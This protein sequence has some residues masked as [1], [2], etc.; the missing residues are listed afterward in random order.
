MNGNPDRKSR[1]CFPAKV[2]DIYQEYPFLLNL[3]KIFATRENG[4][5]GNAPCSISYASSLSRVL[6]KHYKAAQGPKVCRAA[7]KYFENQIKCK[8][9]CAHWSSIALF[10]KSSFL[11]MPLKCWK[12]WKWR[13]E[14]MFLLH[15]YIIQEM[16]ITK[17][18]NFWS[19]S[20]C[21]N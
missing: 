3:W 1:K 8:L 18:S 2:A 20:Y 10:Q 17:W 16:K 5:S 13:C 11:V 7:V 21:M 4:P 19:S 15:N 9:I 14:N 12:Y 6:S